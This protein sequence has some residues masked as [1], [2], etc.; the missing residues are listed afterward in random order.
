MVISAGSGRAKTKTSVWSRIA[1]A[2]TL[3]LTVTLALAFTFGD[4]EA[5]KRRGSRH[6][7]AAVAAATDGETDAKPAAKPAAK[8]GGKKRRGA[9]HVYSPP[10][11]AMVLDANT[12]KVLYSANIDELRYPASVTKVMTLYL[13]FEQLKAGRLKLDT[14]LNV[15]A[16]AAGQA[17]SKLDL[18]P[19]STITVKDAMYALVTKSA[20]D[21]AVVIAENLA[22]SQSEF[23][24]FMTMKARALGM[25]NST[26]RNASGLP[27]TEQRTTARDLVILAHHVLKDF[28]E[29]APIFRTRVF[30]YGGE[31]HR[32]HNGL[33]FTYPGTEGLKTGFTQASGFNL[34]TSVRRGDKHLLAVV[35]GGPSARERNARMRN[36]LNQAWDDASDMKTGKA[37]S[38]VVAS[39]AKS[40]ELASGP[41]AAPAPAKAKP[42]PQAQAPAPAQT[43]QNTIALEDL[44]ERNPAFHASDAERVLAASMARTRELAQ[45]R[46]AAQPAAPAIA[47]Q[48]QRNVVLAAVAAKPETTGGAGTS[49]AQPAAK[50]APAQA[51]AAA[52]EPAAAPA[53]APALPAATHAPVGLGPYH[54]QVG[55]YLNEASAKNRLQFIAAKTA[56][57]LKGHDDVTVSG[58]VDGKTYFRARFGRFSEDDAKTTCAKLKTQAIDCLVIRAE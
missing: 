40:A 37:P 25:N 15:S 31:E 19:G 58:P 5:K 13:V 3:A 48:P 34:L 11:S 7:A 44:P 46:P 22:G 21:A 41:A 42:Q 6:S 27:D 12:G 49:A 47:A 52:A 33:L 20:N 10:Q 32:N 28:P 45:Q 18:T 53:P 26:F 17:P 9:R 56:P 29:Y 36:L 51:A 14:E 35:L 2:I 39:L 1:A 55:S 16:F 4:A 24:R 23:A 38:V 30:T 54:V 50:A 57:L 43:A 8:A